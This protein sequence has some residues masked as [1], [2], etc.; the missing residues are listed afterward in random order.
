MSIDPE[1]ALATV[2]AIGD[3]LPIVVKKSFFAAMSR[4][5]TGAV[6]VPAAWLEGKTQAIRDDTAGRTLIARE[7]AQAAAARF[8]SDPALV[9]RAVSHFGARLLREQSTRESVAAAAAQDLKANPPT[10]DSQSPISDDWLDM[11]SRLSETRTDEDVR[12]YFGKLLAEEIR[13][14][15]SFSPAT[16]Q[17]LASITPSTALLFQKACALCVTFPAIKGVIK[18]LIVC[19]PFG[20]PGDNKL[21]QFGL[22]YMELTLLQSAGLVHTDLNAWRMLPIALFLVGIEVARKPV[23]I[24]SP[25]TP[26]PGP[27]ILER[28][29]QSQ[30]VGIVNLTPV[31]GELFGIV[32]AEPNADYV[33][34]LRAWALSKFPQATG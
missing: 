6:E 32:H 12:L 24:L 7:A 26:A 10:E 16:M 2:A 1:S 22:S 34:G 14:P 9:D 13:K 18:P 3:A 15:G 33:A 25:D 8:G 30:R 21:D 28:L 29:Q 19:E 11:F 27:E 23:L 4:L 17:A 20:Q 31:G 5:I